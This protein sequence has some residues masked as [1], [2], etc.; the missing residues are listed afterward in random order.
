MRTPTQCI[1]V[2]P[3]FFQEI[4]E[5]DLELRELIRRA[6]KALTG[7]GPIRSQ[8]VQFVEVLR[9]LCDRLVAH[10]DLEDTFGY[11]SNPAD[12]SS[13]LSRR[14][15][16]LQSQHQS[17]VSELRTIYEQ[18]EG[19]LREEAIPLAPRGIVRGFDAFCS[20]LYAHDVCEDDLIFM[21]MRMERNRPSGMMS[22]ASSRG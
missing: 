3:T 14:A 19:R 18:A 10:F 13:R 12:G 20:R 22:R 16:T 4:K 15:K 8:W 21:A 2:N 17:L 6:Q 11:F 1:T 7:P 9:P 5:E